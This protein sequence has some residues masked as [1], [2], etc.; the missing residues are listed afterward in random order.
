VALVVV[1]AGDHARVVIDGLDAAGRPVAGCIEVAPDGDLDR[2]VNGIPILGTLDDDA[3]VTAHNATEFVVAL[4]DNRARAEAFDACLRLGLEPTRMIHP[5]ANVL[6]GVEVGPGSQVCAGAVIGLD[7]RIGANA[8]INTL[9]S[10]D[11]DD[12][13]GDHAFIA[14]GVHLAGR[15]TVGTGARVGIGANVREG[16]RIGAWA[17]VAGGAAVVRDVLEHGRVAG[18]PARPMTEDRMAME[19]E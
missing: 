4:G 12:V 9:A 6:G 14:P 19:S 2:L 15:V 8:I 7:A 13:I 18:V 17:T 16:V 10:V 3:W 1:G 11:H 5:S